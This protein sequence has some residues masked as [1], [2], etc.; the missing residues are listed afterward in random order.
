VSD[1]KGKAHRFGGDWTSQKL[2]VIAKYLT[3]Y[4][5]AL[6]KQPFRKAYIDA[7][8]GTGYRTLAV[9]TTSSDLLFPDLS[10]TE[11]QALLEGSALRALRVVPPFEHYIFIERSPERCTH[12][13]ALKKERPE[14]RAGHS[15]RAGRSE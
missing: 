5:T 12:L 10:G 8:A 7:F 6:K 13:E 2:D 1:S 4:T 11:P 9:D 15:G 3:A 14:P